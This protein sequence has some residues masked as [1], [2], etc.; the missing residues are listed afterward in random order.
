MREKVYGGSNVQN[1][2][3]LLLLR[4]DYHFP[5]SLHKL[6][7]RP[8]VASFL[9]FLNGPWLDFTLAGVCF[10]FWLLIG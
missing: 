7:G 3:T 5:L 9:W 10:L 6:S 2:Y 1:Q 8:H 4:L